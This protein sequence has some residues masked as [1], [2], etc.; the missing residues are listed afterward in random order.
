MH[1]LT[2]AYLLT[3]ARKKRVD[4]TNLRCTP[5]RLARLA[6]RFPP[7]AAPRYDN[8]HLRPHPPPPV[9]TPATRLPPGVQ[10]GVDS[11]NNI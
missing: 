10:A 3:T 9:A 8:G 6:P 4:A 5:E 2:I 7:L 1:Y 11:R